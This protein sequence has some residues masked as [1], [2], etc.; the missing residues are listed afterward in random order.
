MFRKLLTKQVNSVKIQQY[1]IKNFGVVGAGQMG[2]GI[3][4][5]A[6]SNAKYQ[7][8]LMDASQ[9]SLNR[10]NN[11]Y[12]SLIQKM[13]QKGKITDNEGKEIKSRIKTTTSLKDLNSCDFVVEAATEHT[14]TKLKIFEELSNNSKDETILASNTSSISIT[15]LAQVTKRPDKVIGMHFMNPV[16]V[17][18]L[19]EVI[20]GLQTSI[21]TYTTTVQ[22]TNEMN[23][24]IVVSKDSPGF[25]INRI[26]MPYINEAVQVLHEGIA[27]AEDIDKGMKLGTN[28]PMGPLTLAEFIGLDTCLSI[29]K[30]LHTEFGDSKYRPSPLLVKMV[31]AGWYGKK[32]GKGFSELKR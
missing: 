24:E 11:Y 14:E 5:V 4:F 30:V 3:G 32:N 1:S 19:V 10:A 21:D 20:N 27:N 7:V 18:K 25:I 31:E 29:M 6:S 26:L 13:I 28:V 16:P 2:S 9:E 22:L 12:D 8:T 23:K 15:K 17:M